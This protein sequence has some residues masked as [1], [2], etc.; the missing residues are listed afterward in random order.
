LRLSLRLL[1]GGKSRLSAQDRSSDLEELERL[2]AAF[3]RQGVDRI[4]ITG[5]E[6]WSGAVSSPYSNA[7]GSGLRA[8][9]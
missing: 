5:G 8:A 2:C 1:H 6:R 9:D 3:I 7:L 4:R